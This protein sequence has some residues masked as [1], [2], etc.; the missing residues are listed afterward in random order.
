MY[1]IFNKTITEAEINN[2]NLSNETKTEI[3]KFL[4][5]DKNERIINRI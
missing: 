2:S 1:E 5:D 3:I 4:E